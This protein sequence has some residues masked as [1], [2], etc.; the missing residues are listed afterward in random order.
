MSNTHTIRPVGWIL[1]SDIFQT[2]KIIGHHKNI[3]CFVELSYRPSEKPVSFQTA[4]L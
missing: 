4:L 2:A 1:E 3:E